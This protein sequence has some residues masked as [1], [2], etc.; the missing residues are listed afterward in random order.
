[1]SSETLF[2]HYY[3]NKIFFFYIKYGKCRNL[4]QEIDVIPIKLVLFKSM[5]F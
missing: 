4:E 1:M 3:A 2:V 5:I